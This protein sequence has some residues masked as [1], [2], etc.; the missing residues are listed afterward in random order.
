LLERSLQSAWSWFQ[1]QSVS[2]RPDEGSEIVFLYSGFR[3]PKKS[4]RKF[5]GRFPPTWLH[6]LAPWRDCGGGYFILSLF[7]SSSPAET[8]HVGTSD[9]EE[10]DSAGFGNAYNPTFRISARVNSITD[11]YRTVVGDCMGS[12]QPSAILT[13]PIDRIS[14]AE[15]ADAYLDHAKVYYRKNGLPT[16]RV[17]I[18]AKILG[19]LGKLYPLKH[20]RPF[21]K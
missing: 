13:E 21:G 14:V 18:V 6:T 20:G 15:L 2:L 9:G 7:P 5:Q 16:R 4:I 8:E 19:L 1:V 17:G 12:C 10:D 3:V 11:D